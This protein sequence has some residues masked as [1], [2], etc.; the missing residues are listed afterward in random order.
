MEKSS[1]SDRIHLVTSD[2]LIHPFD[3]DPYFTVKGEGDCWADTVKVDL[4][5]CYAH[6]LKLVEECVKRT[7]EA[8]PLP[9]FPHYYV[10]EFEG[11]SRT[12]GYANKL[13][14]YREGAKR[15]YEP[16]IMLFGKRIPVH[17]AMTRYLVA[18]EFGHVVDYHINAMRGYQEE[19]T[20]EF[21]REYAKF[22]GC[23][24]NNSYGGKRW[25]LNIGEIIA[26][27]FRIL[28]CGIDE[29]FWQHP[30]VPHPKQVPNLLAFWQDL[31]LECSAQ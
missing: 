27:D 20:T 30:H 17:P 16:Y 23:E 4:F 13:R 9:Q 6:D 25:H 10:P 11:T 2:D 31:K 28:M 5:P 12:N 3:G 8:F 21:D 7:E 22:R 14:N 29:D 1:I 24:C 15:A 18:H 26:N 19:T